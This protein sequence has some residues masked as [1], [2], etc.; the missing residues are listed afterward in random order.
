LAFMVDLVSGER[1][2]CSGRMNLEG[3]PPVG[4]R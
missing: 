4:S 1:A 3:H 2:M